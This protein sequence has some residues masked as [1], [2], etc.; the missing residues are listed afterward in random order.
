MM[1]PTDRFKMLCVEPGTHPDS[2]VVALPMASHLT[3]VMLSSVQP[4]F[5]N[6]LKHKLRFSDN[7]G[8]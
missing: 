4:L 5:F 7:T 8:A 2:R 3:F 6:S 1:S